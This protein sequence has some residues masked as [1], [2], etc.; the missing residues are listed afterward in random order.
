MA[1]TVFISSYMT[2]VRWDVAKLM[3]CDL[4]E[5]FSS[6]YRCH[7]KVHYTGYKHHYSTCKIENVMKNVHLFFIPKLFLTSII[8]LI[9]LAKKQKPALALVFLIWLFVWANVFLWSVRL[10]KCAMLFMMFDASCIMSGL[11]LFKKK[12]TLL[13]NCCVDA[14]VSGVVWFLHV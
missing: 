9:T 13:S 14:L 11:C 10:S 12:N 3:Q 8:F 5:E 6:F 1:I 7:T 4:S 2:D